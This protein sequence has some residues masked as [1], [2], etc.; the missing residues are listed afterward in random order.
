[1]LAVYLRLTSNW[2][3]WACLET[4]GSGYPLGHAA[5]PAGCKL[6][7]SLL[8]WVGERQGW[9]SPGALLSV[10]TRAR[11]WVGGGGR[12]CAKSGSGLHP[13]P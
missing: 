13:L 2:G 3:V 9:G 7:P 10:F 5:R 1:M 8:V 6:S 4:L 12:G 11:R